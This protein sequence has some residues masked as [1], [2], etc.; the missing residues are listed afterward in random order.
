M[1]LITIPPDNGVPYS[2]YQP[3]ADEIAEAQRIAKGLV[4]MAKTA[5]LDV[6]RRMHGRDPIPMPAK[7]TGRQRAI[8][9]QADADARAYND[10]LTRYALRAGD[11]WEASGTAGTDTRVRLGRVAIELAVAS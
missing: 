4:A 1:T 11:A 2:E 9:V 6:F 3:T 8:A 7:I 5:A 10:M